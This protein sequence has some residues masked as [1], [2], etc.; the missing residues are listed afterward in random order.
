MDLQQVRRVVT[1]YNAKGL[2]VFSQDGLIEKVSPPAGSSKT[3]FSVSTVL[4]VVSVEADNPL[5]S[6]FGAQRA[7]PLNSKWTTAVME[8][9]LWA[10][11]L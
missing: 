9:R 3:Q 6:R 11:P 4:Q 2:S 5:S 7:F 1:A 10:N 8:Q